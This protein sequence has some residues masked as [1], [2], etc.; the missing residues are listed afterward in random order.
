MYNH[1]YNHTFSCFCI[2]SSWPCLSS[3]KNE[4]KNPSKVIHVTSCISY[5][6]ILKKSCLAF[7]I[8][9]GTMQASG[10]MTNN[11]FTVK[12]NL[13]NKSHC[14]CLD[15]MLHLTL[16]NLTMSLRCSF[17]RSTALKGTVQPNLHLLTLMLF[18]HSM[19][20]IFNNV[21]QKSGLDK[22]NLNTV[23][24]KICIRVGTISLNYC[25]FCATVPQQQ[26]VTLRNK[27][28]SV[29]QLCTAVAHYCF[30][31]HDPGTIPDALQSGT[32]AYKVW[33]SSTRS[34]EAAQ[35]SSQGASDPSQWHV[36][37]V[38]F[39]FIPWAL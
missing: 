27:V 26:R 6:F 34:G 5:I 4:E 37:R 35:L 12:S 22:N 24:K 21:Q 10:L 39:S 19:L 1:L 7:Q 30:W 15:I 14:G 20:F 8:K 33:L 11:H 32:V 3:S 29:C 36:T 23:N 13:S 28:T 2:N 31:P 17:I 38:R 18:Q 25:L 9:Y 16:I